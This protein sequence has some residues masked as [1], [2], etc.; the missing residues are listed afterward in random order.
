MTSVHAAIELGRA[1]AAQR[2][3]TG[4]QWQDLFLLWEQESGWNPRAR[5]PSSGAAGIPQDITGNF[6]GGT[7]GQI[8][9]GDNYIAGRYGT[10]A[11]ALQHERAFGW[12]GNGGWVNEPVLGVG[13]RTGQGYGFAENGSEYISKNGPGGNTYNININVSPLAHPADVGREVVKAVKQFEKRNGAGWRNSRVSSSGAL[14][15][16]IA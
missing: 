11:R 13:L 9:W 4:F 7:R 16:G 15:R 5:N 2:G 3:W 10:P 14:V 12:Y 8:I 1:M 6:H